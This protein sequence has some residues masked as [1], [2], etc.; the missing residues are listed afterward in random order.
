M[1]TIK[2]SAPASNPGIRTA[3]SVTSIIG[4]PGASAAN[5]SSLWEDAPTEIERRS[6]ILEVYGDSGTGRSTFAFSAPPPIAYLFAAEKTEGIVQRA[7]MR[8][9]QMGSNVRVHNFGAVF[10]GQDN[11]AIALQAKPVLDALLAAFYDSLNW[12]RTIILDTHTEAWELFR[13]GH[14]GS[15]KPEGGRVDSNYGPVNALWRSMFKAA[16]LKE[17]CNFIVIGQTKDEWVTKSKNPTAGAEGGIAKVAF[18]SQR[19]GKGGSDGIGERTGRTVRA[20]QKEIV[21]LCD[22]IVRT[23]KLFEDTGG[24]TFSS[25]IEKGWYNAEY[26][27][28]EFP[29]EKSNFSNVMAVL[30]E[31]DPAEW[32][33]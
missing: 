17:T 31:S 4:A 2:T 21:P 12:A 30:T 9:R 25:R 10:T 13:I 1:A 8:A 28:M 7:Q 16:R 22:V 19:K 3:P 15:F 5:P 18:S 11:D 32:A 26:E 20:G 6:V 27:G 29:A 14:F 24:S 23:N 33:K